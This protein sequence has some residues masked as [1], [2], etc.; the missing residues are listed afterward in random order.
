MKGE[1]LLFLDHAN[2]RLTADDARPATAGSGCPRGPFASFAVYAPPRRQ[3]PQRRPRRGE[4][5]HRRARLLLDARRS[6][7]S[8]SCCRS[9]SPTPRTSASSTRWSCRTSPTALR[10]DGKPA[11]P[12]GAW[13]VDGHGP[14]HLRGPRRPGRRPGQRRRDRASTGPGPAIG[15]GTV[16]AF[17]RRLVSSK[18]RLAPLVRADV[19]LPPAAPHLHLRRPGHRGRPP[20]PPRPGP[21]LRR[22]RHPP[23]GVRAQGADAAPPA[24]CCSW[25]STSSTSTRRARARRPSRRSCSTWPSGAGRSASSSSAPSRR[26]ARSSG[27]SSPTP[28]CGSSAGSTPPRRPGPSTASC[29]RP[30]GGGPPSP[31]PARCSSTSRRS[32]CRSWSSSRSRPG[33][34]GPLSCVPRA[35]L[36]APATDDDPFDG[37]VVKLLHTAD[38]HVGKVLKG[39]ERLD[40]QR[41]VLAEI[42][43]R[44][45]ARGRRR[46]CVVAGDVFESAAPAAEAQRLAWATLLAL[47]AT[48]AEVVVDRRQPRPRRVRSTRGRRSSPAPAS[49][50][51]AG[52]GGPTTAASSS[53]WPARTGERA[54]RGAP[55]V[56]VA[57]RRRARRR[58]ARARRGPDGRRLRRAHRRRRRPRSPT[59]FDGRRRQ[60]RRRPRHRRAAACSGAASGTPR[61]SSSTPCPPP[62]SRRR[63]PTSAL[64]HLHRLQELPAPAPGLVPRVADRRRLRRGGRH[65]ARGA[66]SSVAGH[67]GQG[68][69][70]T[71]R[72]ASR[73][74]ARC[75]GTVAELAALARR[76]GR[77]PAAGGRHRAARAG[78]G[79]R[80]AAAA[81]Q[82]PRGRG[83]SAPPTRARPAPRSPPGRTPH[84]LF[85]AYLTELDDRRPPPRAPV[86]RAARR[87]A[88]PGA[89]ADAPGAASMLEG[90]GAFRERDRSRLRRHRLL[91]PRRPTGSGKSTVIDAICFALY[92]SV[93]RYGDERLVGSAM[94]VGHQE[95]RVRLTFEVGGQRYDGRPGRAA[96]PAT[97][98]SPRRRPGSRTADGARAGREGQ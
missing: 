40:E 83:S 43:A 35:T 55:A 33:P 12:D 3:R 17:V 8:R 94:S 77:R 10:R 95:T 84:E 28:R 61:R 71:A 91:R 62:S 64:G 81:A 87:R 52:R 88:V 20:Q 67:A 15:M 9:C 5:D 53:W 68:A 74:C 4:P 48:G 98:G 29:P 41:A 54:A 69:G 21:A 58:A 30:S 27:A 38:W 24:R 37:V 76:P 60:R 93:P 25:C 22:G 97:A 80:G 59:G 34:P 82:R 47:R 44:R 14:A 36:P 50:C 46:S 6:S 90:F 89:A 78:L 73:R 66:S 75:A 79:R 56:R 42:V 39:V 85:A 23:P 18:H 49:R 26:P 70:R 51:S 65:Q 45:R 63:R 96:G 11:G 19:A 13:Q 1:D 31:S 57:A 16:N 72:V 32:P 86:R 92:G 2:A 7:A